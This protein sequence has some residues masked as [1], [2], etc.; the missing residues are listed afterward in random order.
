MGLKS[1]NPDFNILP[2][3]YMEQTGHISGTTR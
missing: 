3:N 1:L 2:A